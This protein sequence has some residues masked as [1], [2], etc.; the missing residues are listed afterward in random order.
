MKGLWSETL[1]LAM[2]VHKLSISAAEAYKKDLGFC[3][4]YLLEFNHQWM[5]E[6]CILVCKFPKENHFHPHYL[7]YK[8][9]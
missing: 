8:Q 4:H 9:G 5:C 7:S 1:F 3:R 2:Y 6:F